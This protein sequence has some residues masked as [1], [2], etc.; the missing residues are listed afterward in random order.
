MIEFGQEFG[1]GRFKLEKP[2]FDRQGTW[3]VIGLLGAAQIRDTDDRQAV[4]AVKS[5]L[6]AI[7]GEIGI[8]FVSM[9]DVGDNKVRVLVKSKNKKK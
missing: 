2:D 9:S 6:Q 5:E 7:L 4:I 3:Y 8:S 1:N